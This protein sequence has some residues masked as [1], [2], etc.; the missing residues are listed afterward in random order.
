MIR[1]VRGDLRAAGETNHELLWPCVSAGIFAPAAAWFAFGLP[2]PECLF[3]KLT[4]VPCVTCGAT[5]AAIQ[6]LHG[7]FIAAWTW[8]P[9][10]TVALIGIAAFNAYAVAVLLFGLPRLRLKPLSP[11]GRNTLRIAMFA[12]LLANWGYVIVHLRA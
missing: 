2:W 4:G 7:N 6:F 11:S 12:A 1:L 5:R 10:V 9:L 3:H 8:N